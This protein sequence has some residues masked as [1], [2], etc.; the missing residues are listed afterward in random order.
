MRIILAS[1]NTA[2]TTEIAAF[3]A[4]LGIT[5]LNYRDVLPQQVFPD[6]TTD[7]MAAN[8]LQK[9]A[10][11]AKMLP[12]EYVLGDDSGMFI[13]ALPEHFG[14]VTMR[15]FIAHDAYDDDAVNN[16]VL[17]L[18][19]QHSNRRGYLQADFALVTPNGYLQ[20]VGRGGVQVAS[21]PRGSYSHG[22]D[23][24]FETE[25][26]KTLAELPIKQR[27]P[28]AHRGRAAQDLV[29]QLNGR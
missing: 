19:A 16:Y 17:G 20:S 1:N 11:I 29:A 3:F 15:E 23:D 8:A 12:D 2:K 10:F 5:V 13:T 14:A 9:A 27:L 24:I 25:T 21:A 28:Y 7:D 18:L 6:E 4:Q 22:L 26:G